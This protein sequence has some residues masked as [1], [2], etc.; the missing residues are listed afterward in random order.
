[1]EMEPKQ[2]PQSENPKIPKEQWKLPI[3]YDS[4]NKEISLE[5]FNENY[6]GEE[7]INSFVVEEY[8]EEELHSLVMKRLQEVENYGTF[9]LGNN[10]IDLDRA[11]LEVKN[12]TKLGEVIIEIEMETIKAMLKNLK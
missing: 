12:N 9:Q 6:R 7:F 5:D 8:S 3:G 4:E 11:K 2:F 1:M 10:I